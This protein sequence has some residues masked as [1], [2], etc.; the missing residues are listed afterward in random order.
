[1]DDQLESELTKYALDL[2]SKLIDLTNELIQYSELS[3]VEK[4]ALTNKANN[5]ISEIRLASKI[6]LS[7]S[8]LS[9]IMRV[10]DIKTKV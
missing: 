3:D 9:A 2:K 1:M 7:Y 10:L 6:I 5:C 4:E 8:D